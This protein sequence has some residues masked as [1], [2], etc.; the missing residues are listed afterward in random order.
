MKH[1]HSNLNDKCEI[2]V[3][4][5]NKIANSEKLKGKK[6][7]ILNQPH[8]VIN[9][10]FPLRLDSGET[11]VVE[12]YRVQYNNARGP[13]KGGIRFH[14]DVDMQEVRGLAFL[15]TLKCALLDIPLGGGKGG[16]KIDPN[17]LSK[18][19]L[20]RLSRSYAKEFTPFIGPDVDVPAPDVNTNPQ[21]MA[22]MLDEYEKVIGKKCPAAFTGKPLALGG[23]QVRDVSTSLGGFYVLDDYMRLKGMDKS[24]ATVAIQGYGNVG[25]N[26]AK[27]LFQNGFKIVA[28]S[29]HTGAFLDETGIDITSASKC[30]DVTGDLSKC[31]I[32]KAITNEEI[33]ELPVDILIPAALGHVI[34]EKNASK[35]KAKIVLELANAPISPQA[36]EIL[37]KNKV[38]VIPDFLANSGGVLVSYF[39]WMQNKSGAYWPASKVEMKLKEKMVTAF[40]DVLN[41]A[42]T[43]KCTLRQAAYIIAVDRIVEAEKLRGYY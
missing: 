11:I 19:E 32:G 7:E 39:E 41:V 3:L 40:N 17:K 42:N 8:R 16:V 13:Y 23:S 37:E 22:W 10:N 28:I 38:A 34:S 12:A 30:K 26:I 9:I 4:Q 18:N 21:V 1:A 43:E 36:D 35:I 29:D 31:T 5:L 14:Q 25:M 27:I 33:L 6:T 15:M 24:K 20:E 2:C